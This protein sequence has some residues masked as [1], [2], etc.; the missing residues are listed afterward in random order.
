M[1]KIGYE[2]FR[3]INAKFQEP[4]RA[5]NELFLTPKMDFIDGKR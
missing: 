1:S 4:D 3:I 2:T 5:M